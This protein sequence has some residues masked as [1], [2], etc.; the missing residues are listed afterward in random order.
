MQKRTG[1]SLVEM[2]TVLAVLA[3]LA[4]IVL[5][6]IVRAR[7]RRSQVLCL[8]NL[9]QIHHAM[10]L[11]LSDYDGN[12]PPL[13]QAQINSYDNTIVTWNTLI[14]PYDASRLLDHCPSVDKTMDSVKTAPPQNMTGYA[15]NMQLGKPSSFPGFSGS[16]YYL[17]GR[18]ES[19]VQSPSRT[20]LVAECRLGT[21]GLAQPDAVQSRVGVLD[22]YLRGYD[23]IDI[24]RLDGFVVWMASLWGRRLGYSLPDLVRLYMVGTDVSKSYSG[25]LDSRG[26]SAGDGP[27]EFWRRGADACHRLPLSGHST[28]P[29]SNHRCAEVMWRA[30]QI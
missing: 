25:I 15:L 21:L 30:R 7:Q 6:V 11:Y 26:R 18:P 4:A 14:L 8:A 3:V 20:V 12:F 29:S 24:Q 17:N 28:T 16:Q 23:D 5:P 13:T 27:A 1:F 9:Q 19:D 22:I 2:L 10:T